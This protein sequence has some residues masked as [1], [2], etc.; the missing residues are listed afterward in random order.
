LRKKG[1]VFTNPGCVDAIVDPAKFFRGQID[2][3]LHR[4]RVAHVDY[5]AQGFV[6]LVRGQLLTLFSG[7]GGCVSADIREENTGR[8]CFGECEARFLSD[9]A[10]ALY[11]TERLPLAK[12]Y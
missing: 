4:F 1:N 7:L 12:C 6:S 5:C 9:S 8:A 3:L 2:H 10:S 11:V